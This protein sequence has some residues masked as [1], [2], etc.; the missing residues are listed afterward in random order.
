MGCTGN[1]TLVATVIAVP[2]VNL[3]RDTML[4]SGNS[5]VLSG[6]TGSAYQWSTGDTTASVTVSA[7]GTYILKIS[8][9]S[10]SS[11]DTVVV[12]IAPVPVVNLG[13][14]TAFCAG[15]TFLLDALNPGAAYL[16]STGSNTQTI[17]VNSTQ[18][19]WVRVRNVFGCSASDTTYVTVNPFPVAAFTID[20]S[21]SPVMVFSNHS[22]NAA[23]YLWDFGDQDTSSVPGP[24][25]AYGVSGTYVV[26]LL[27]VNA[28]GAD[29][30]AHTI[31]V[32]RS[33]VNNA[34]SED[35]VSIYPN[36]ATDVVHIRLEGILKTDLELY[37]MS[38]RRICVPVQPAT[39]GFIINTGSLSG[40]T[41]TL[42]IRQ[43]NAIVTRKLVIVK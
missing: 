29:S 25:H 4:C 9:A 28:C 34:V 20:S 12:G 18:K 11:G 7:A 16:W 33:G 36:P 40:G 43:N 2:G 13:P 30:M 10:C 23:N 8:N 39:G 17:V 1:D 32:I 22:L 21:N 19:V 31:R 26:K 6:G 24:V 3:G 27:A 5:M 15:N 14:D 42:L 38:S 41:Y 35:H 37:D